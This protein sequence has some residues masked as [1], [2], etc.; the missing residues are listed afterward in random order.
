MQFGAGANHCP[1]ADMHLAVSAKL[2]VHMLTIVDFKFLQENLCAVRNDMTFDEMK[3][4]FKV[5]VSLPKTGPLTMPNSPLRATAS[6]FKL[7][8]TTAPEYP[9]GLTSSY[10]PFTIAGAGFESVAKFLA[11]LKGGKEFVPTVIDTSIKGADAIVT[12]VAKG[13]QPS[14]TLRRSPRTMVLAIRTSSPSARRSA[15]TRL[16]YC[17]SAGHRPSS[18]SCRTVRSEHG[19]SA[20]SSSK[21]RHARWSSASG[22]AV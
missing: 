14:A 1:G 7:E 11:A 21:R 20:A 16:R 9:P 2:L 10:N 17:C 12:P 19:P 6:D 3:D 15:T 22:A 13:H 8:T 5:K 4:F 18:S